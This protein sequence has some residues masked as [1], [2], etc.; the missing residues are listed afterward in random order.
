MAEDLELNDPRIFFVADYV[1][2]T[3]KLKSDKFAK[4]YGQEESKVMIHEFFEKAD[5]QILVLQYTTSGSLQPS[6]SFPNLLKNKSCYFIKKRKEPLPKDT[7]LRDALMYGDLSTSPVEQ[8][9]AMVD[10]VRLT[11]LFV[12]F[13]YLCFPSLSYFFH[14]YKIHRIMRHGRKFYLKIFFVMRWASKIKFTFLTAR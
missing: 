6:V 13:F 5:Y 11:S 4:M 8:L 7:I 3:L 12:F 9:S 1:L 14:C 10:E 2:K